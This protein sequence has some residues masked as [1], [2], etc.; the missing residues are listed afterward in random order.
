MNRPLWHAFLDGFSG[1]GLFQDL[2]WSGRTR[3]LEEPDEWDRR[4]AVVARRYATGGLL[5]VLICAAC[6]W[7]SHRFAAY[8][9]LGLG[10]IRVVG[11]IPVK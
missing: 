4:Y 3:S 11:A 5:M 9:L 7:P 10:A 1:A 8:A 2:R 6:L